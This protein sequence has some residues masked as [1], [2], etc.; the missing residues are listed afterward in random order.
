MEAITTAYIDW[1]GI[2]VVFTIPDVKVGIGTSSPLTILHVAGNIICSEPAITNHAATKLYVDNATNNL[3]P[4]SYVDSATNAIPLGNYLSLSGGTMTGNI[5]LDG[6]M[7][8]SADLSSAT[9]INNLNASGNRIVSMDDP[10]DS[11]DGVNL[12]TLKSFTNSTLNASIQYTDSVS[13]SIDNMYVRIDGEDTITMT[14]D[15]ELTLSNLYLPDGA[16]ITYKYYA[17]TK[18]MYFY[19][20]GGYAAF[21]GSS[22]SWASTGQG[23]S[24]SGND[25]K[26]RNAYG[27]FIW[28][29]KESPTLVK[30]Y[31]GVRYENL[32][33][34]DSA[35]DAVNLETLQ[36]T[37]NEMY[38]SLVNVSGDTVT[39]TLSVVSLVVTGSNNW[40]VGNDIS[41][42]QTHIVMM[43]D[44]GEIRSIY[45]LILNAPDGEIICN[46]PVKFNA[47][48][49]DGA[50]GST[51]NVSTY[52]TG[53][54]I[55]VGCCTASSVVILT[56]TTNSCPA[57]Y[58]V[59]AQSGGF[60]VK[61][62]TTNLWSFNYLVR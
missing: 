32:L 14:P 38:D 33:A 60:T 41:N 31:Y 26:L 49:S 37:T 4:V 27:D 15:G 59:E 18:R 48:L 24:K 13:N 11:Q 39:G 43:S 46:A 61:S 7:L 36:T 45:D 17:G 44:G 19:T 62:D 40:Y 22:L 8:S 35:D 16:Y 42:Q 23:V 30:S 2:K 54:T 56:P 25:F 57:K 50:A 20:P 21:S 10:V 58:W 52:D 5:I 12:Q 51:N 53:A 55:P 34:P 29:S 3:A 9:L 6:N 47:G 28:H 1:I